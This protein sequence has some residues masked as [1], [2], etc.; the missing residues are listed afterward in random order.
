[1]VAAIEATARVGTMSQ[2]LLPEWVREKLGIQPGDLVRFVERDG[3]VMI[4]R[5]EPAF[6]E[7]PFALF[8]EWSSA[9][10]KEAFDEL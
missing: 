4:D 5:L 10:D 9:A 7:D 1:M 6:A 3:A 8:D 2:V